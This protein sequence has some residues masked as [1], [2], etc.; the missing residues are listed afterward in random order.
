M[1]EGKI[2][3]WI[4]KSQNF[5]PKL[6]DNTGVQVKASPPTMER[7]AA[8][9]EPNTLIRGPEK[10]KRSSIRSHLEQNLIKV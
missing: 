4:R 3:F 7:T 6:K 9:T 10:I 2:G 5:T 1:K 8:T